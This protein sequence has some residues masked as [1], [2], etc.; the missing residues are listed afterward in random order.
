MKK[1]KHLHK[2]LG[3]M[4]EEEH[5][6]LSRRAEEFLTLRLTANPTVVG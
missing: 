6:Y 5:K 1:H 4:K 2:A 3:L